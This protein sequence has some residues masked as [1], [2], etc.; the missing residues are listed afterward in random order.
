MLIS[1]SVVDEIELLEKE[2]YA[3]GGL[4]PKYLALSKSMYI[5]LKEERGIPVYE[6]IPIYRGYFIYIIPTDEKIVKFI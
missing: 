2:L 6:E 4:R 3:K 1:V 5:N